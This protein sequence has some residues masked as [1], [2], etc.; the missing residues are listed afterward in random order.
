MEGWGTVAPAAK[1]V[2]SK[3]PGPYWYFCMEECEPVGKR[4]G[5]GRCACLVGC[6][7]L[8]CAFVSAARKIRVLQQLKQVVVNEGHVAGLSLEPFGT[9]FCPEPYRAVCFSCM[10]KLS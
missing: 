3:T 2:L 4:R 1:Q 7:T 8:F 5:D 10:D 6:L 9:R